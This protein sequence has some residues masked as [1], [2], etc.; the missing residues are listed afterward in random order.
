LNTFRK[1]VQGDS[2]AIS[3]ELTIPRESTAD[4]V[5][6]QADDLA[7]LADGI[8]VTD[9]PYAW[10]QMSALAASTIL[11]EHGFDPVPV[12]TCRDRNRWALQ[13]DL[14]GLQAIGVGNVMLM[15]GHRV[16]KDHSVQAST[17][18]DL[19]GQELIALAASLGEDVF[20]GTGARLFR[21]GPRW[22]GE[23]LTRRAAA[24]ARFVQTQ[25]C[26]NMEILERYMQRF[27]AAGLDRDYSIM[28]SLSP[29][30]SASTARWVRKH[31]SDSRIPVEVIQRLED[32]ADP[33][34]EGIEICAGLMQQ[35]SEVPGVSG[36]NLMTTGDP[37]AL[38]ATI[39]ASGLRD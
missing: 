17:V 38:R 24:G 30:P 6:R 23:S 13:S 22:Q 4:D 1:A 7:G 8:Q 5:R 26:F 36:V 10:V 37:G 29:L 27:L 16:P 18:F 28:V 33:E 20:I 34:K 9:N 32:A 11:M 21:P 2:F 12:M 15:R 19:T 14:M 3:A 31:L 39:K 25:L 35:I